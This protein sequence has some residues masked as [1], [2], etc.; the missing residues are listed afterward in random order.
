MGKFRLLLAKQGAERFL[1]DEGI[2]TLPVDPFAIAESRDII[3][4]G[5]PPEVEGVSGMLHRYGN[6]FG[7]M[8]ATSIASPGF[9]RFSVSHELGH[10][11]L[12]GHIDH[13]LPVDGVHVSRA[14]FVTENS[15]ELEADHFAA[16]LLMPRKPFKKALADRVPGLSVIREMAELCDTSLTA[17]AIRVA[18]LSDAAVA[19][20][21]S[22]GNT[23]DYCFRSDAMK[24]LPKLDW[25]HKDSPVPVGTP[26]SRLAADVGRVR[27]GGVIEDEIDIRDWFGGTQKAFV[28]AESIGLGNY[29]K[30]LTIL[31]SAHI[32]R[33]DKPSDE[34]EEADLI[35]SWKPKFRR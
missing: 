2:D 16:G 27:A 8:Y 20:I 26:T 10:Y 28:Y 12:P 9:Q 5:K 29:G 24:S 33:E 35:D 14:G 22:T 4:Q 30:V 11:F 31:S 15:Y 3:V 21:L 17:T 7:I 6:T 23:V 34:Q 32:G 1:T 25:V 18:E 19:V 13:V